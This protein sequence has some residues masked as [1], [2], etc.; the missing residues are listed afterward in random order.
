MN[1]RFLVDNNL[2]DM[3]VTNNNAKRQQHVPTR[4]PKRSLYGEGK[5]LLGRPRPNGLII[6]NIEYI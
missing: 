2:I 3:R 1:I 4:Y 6:L 5:W